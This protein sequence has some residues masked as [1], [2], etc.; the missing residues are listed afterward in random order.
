MIRQITITNSNIYDTPL[1]IVLSLPTLSGFVVRSID[2]LGPSKSNI[3]VRENSGKSG[4]LFNSARTPARNIVFTF[5]FLPIGSNIEGRTGPSI[6]NT[7]LQSYKYFPNESRI[8]IDV[9]TDAGLFYIYG[10]VESNEP[11][12]FSSNEGAVI[13]VICPDPFFRD[14]NGLQG[15]AV[16][17]TAP[18]F[19]FP[20]ENASL[21]EDLIVL[22]E[23]LF[24]SENFS[25]N[26]IGTVDVEPTLILRAEGG[27][28][29]NPEISFFNPNNPSDVETLKFS[30]TTELPHLDN[31]DNLTI[32]C[33]RQNK[34]V[35]RYI[36]ATD[37]YVN[38]LGAVALDS[39]WP[40]LNPGDNLF[41][42]T[43]PEGGG[44]AYIRFSYEYVPKYIGI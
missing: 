31:G 30:F 28:V 26:N 21:S 20:L 39:S 9:E 27:E 40:V 10:Y 22:G 43:T 23:R 32:V 5:E 19:V 17:S 3:S 24:Q 33:E 15:N 25:I 14:M 38:Y 4:G 2:G 36:A 41:S 13:S 44:A 18:L 12:I 34:S 7:R 42:Y 29:N 35:T 11:T 16:I 6:E 37:E 8:R 1:S